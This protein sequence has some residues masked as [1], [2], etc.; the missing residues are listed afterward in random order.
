M[1]SRFQWE[2]RIE[3]LR[4]LNNRSNGWIILCI[5][6]FVLYGITPN[7]P[8]QFALAGSPYFYGIVLMGASLFYELY[9]N[10]ENRLVPS[11]TKLPVAVHPELLTEAALEMSC[12]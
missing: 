9:Q 5:P 7:S 12:K 4:D 10:Q 3:D 8:T 11:E 2:I 6:L 1:R